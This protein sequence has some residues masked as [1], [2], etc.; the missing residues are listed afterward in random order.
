MVRKARDGGVWQVR[1]ILVIECQSKA[2][3]QKPSQRQ[4]KAPT[5]GTVVAILAGIREL[6]CCR[7]VSTRALGAFLHGRREVTA[8]PASPSWYRLD[9]ISSCHSSVRACW[10]KYW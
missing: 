9:G 4:T 6:P 3:M 10:G 2:I 5:I 8:H 7:V 1:T